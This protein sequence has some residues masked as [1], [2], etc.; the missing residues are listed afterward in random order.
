MPVEKTKYIRDV[1]AQY[2]NYR[3]LRLTVLGLVSPRLNRY[4]DREDLRSFIDEYFIRTLLEYDPRSPVDLPGYMK[5]ML[6]TRARG[7]FIT[8][9]KKIDNSE[10][11]FDAFDIIELQAEDEYESVNPF[12]DDLIDYI[13]KSLALNDYEVVAVSGIANGESRYAITKRLRERF[14]E[15][16][17]Q[18]SF[19]IYSDCLEAVKSIVATYLK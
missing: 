5:T 7:T 19:E 1:E 15:M 3:N 8:A 4:E 13:A 18:K 2:D 14:S 17:Q 9:H 12:P 11:A 10:S 6:T 16:T